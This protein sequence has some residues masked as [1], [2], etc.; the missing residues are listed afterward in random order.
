MSATTTTIDMTP[1]APRRTLD[2]SALPK[3]KLDTHAPLWWGNL[4]AIFIE[5]TTLAILI[6]TY[7]YTRRNFHDWPPTRTD[8]QPILFHNDANPDLGFAT[9][10]LI[11]MLLSVAPMIW[12]ERRARRMEERPVKMGLWLMF[13]LTLVLITLRA[14]ELPGLKFKW[15]DN[16]YGSIVWTTMVMHLTYLIAGGLEFLIMA[17]WTTR[18]GLDESHALDVTLAGFYWYWVAATFLVVYAVIFVTPWIT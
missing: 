1:P 3:V 9:A 4:L 5:T 2:V 13:A 18:H 10:E 15:N 8:R 14:F 16:A 6:A 12:L 11:L 17:L 7:F